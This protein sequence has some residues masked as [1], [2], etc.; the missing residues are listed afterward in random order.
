MAHY[1]AIVQSFG[2]LAA[3]ERTLDI[4]AVVGFSEDALRAAMEP[5]S[6]NTLH[7]S[8][9]VMKVRARG[10]SIRLDWLHVYRL[11]YA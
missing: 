5:A 4:R 6:R 11:L 10:S 9:I 2:T 7:H 8:L 3:E 1:A